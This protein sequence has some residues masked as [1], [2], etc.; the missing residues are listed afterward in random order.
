MSPML[1]FDGMFIMFGGMIRTND[2]RTISTTTIMKLDENTKKWSAIGE[3]RQ[4]RS[5]IFY[6][7]I[8]VLVN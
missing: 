1:Y 4:K 3:L 8:Y 2:K 5:I 7:L 6:F